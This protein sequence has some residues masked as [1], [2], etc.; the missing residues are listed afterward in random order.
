M[1]EEKTILREFKVLNKYGIH[2]RPAALLV[3]TAGKFS[4]DIFI[5]RQDMEVSAKSIMGLLTIEGHQGACLSVR[6][7]GTDAEEAMAEIEK[8]FENRFFED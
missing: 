5:G 4:C 3:K 2:A 8:L 7:V 1:T 6:I